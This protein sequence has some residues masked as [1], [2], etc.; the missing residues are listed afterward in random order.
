M[1]ETAVIIYNGLNL[2]STLNAL[3]LHLGRISYWHRGILYICAIFVCVQSTEAVFV[4]ELRIH[5]SSKNSIFHT[6]LDIVQKINK[7]INRL[8]ILSFA[9]KFDSEAILM[10][11]QIKTA[12]ML[13]YL[14][15]I[16]QRE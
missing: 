7:T 3:R 2:P 6:I 16:F 15:T 8:Q 5:C 10:R 1:A 9:A 11:I 12:V 4:K 14:L 13:L